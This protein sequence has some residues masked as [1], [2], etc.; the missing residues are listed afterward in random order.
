MLLVRCSLSQ[1]Y[2]TECK[3]VYIQACKQRE[4]IHRPCTPSVTPL[5]GDLWG[6]SSITL[7]SHN[8]DQLSGTTLTT[9]TDCCTLADTAHYN[10]HARTDAQALV[11]LATGVAVC[12]ESGQLGF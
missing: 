7:H 11:G 8:S 3:C 10:R 12:G 9:T 1:S 5:R 6:P 2:L 4:R